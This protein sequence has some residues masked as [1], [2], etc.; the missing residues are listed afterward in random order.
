MANEVELKFDVEAGG[1]ASVRAAPALAATLSEATALETVYFDT[2]DG[3]LRRAGFSLRVRRSGQRHVQTV[4]RK[5]GKAAGLFIRQEWETDVGGLELDHDALRR[6]PVKKLLE[7]LPADALVPLIRCR[8]RRTSWLI[9]DK[10]SRIEVVLDE[11]QV[12]SGRA[13]APLLELELELLAGKPRRLFVLAEELGRAVPLRLGVLS[14]AERG[15]ALAE[16]RLGRSSRAEPVDLDLPCAEGDAFRI[17]AHACLRH[18]RLNEIALLAGRDPEALHQARIALRQLRA[19]LSLFRSTVRG[20]D[21]QALRDEIGWLAGRFGD[22]RDL[23]VMLAGEQ[24]LAHDDLLHARLLKARARAYDKVEAALHSERTR[25]LMLRIALWT[26]IGPWRFRERSRRDVAALAADQL[27]RQWHKVR[28]HGA[29]IADAKRD[30]R[31]RL[32]L[33]IKRLRYSAEF[34]AGLHGKRPKSIRRDRFI[35]ALKDLQDRLGELTDAEAAETVT[36]RIGPGLSGSAD[37]IRRRA[38]AGAA[39]A[40]AHEA[41][42]RGAA[43]AGYWL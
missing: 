4:K 11:G 21:Y 5:R 13:K 37:R 24:G 1:A 28:R 27:E 9:A 33:D 18:Y 15:Y 31:H 38:V 29:R 40:A 32:R 14:K 43:T 25:A 41:L 36:R 2:S 34:L 16:R 26:E 23:D 20:S 35:D 17:V 30:E 7:S 12:E 8:F 3:A 39:V 42:Q 22:A 6:S 10:N 19:A